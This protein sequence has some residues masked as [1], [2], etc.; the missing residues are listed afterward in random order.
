MVRADEGTRVSWR[1]TDGRAGVRESRSERIKASRRM[2]VLMWD[3]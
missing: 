3:D 1:V 2:R